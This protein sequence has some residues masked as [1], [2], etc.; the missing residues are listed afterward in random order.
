MRTIGLDA[1]IAFTLWGSNSHFRPATLNLCMRARDAPRQILLL[2]HDESLGQIYV[3]F[4]DITLLAD[5]EHACFQHPG[6]KSR[7]CVLPV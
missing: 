3:S 2:V 4:R 6:Y 5:D 1:T 7:C